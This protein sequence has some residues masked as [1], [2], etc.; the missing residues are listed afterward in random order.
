M[1]SNPDTIDIVAQDPK[2][3]K[4]LLVM[5]EDRPW[6]DRAHLHQDFH[7]KAQAYAHYVLSDQFTQ[8]HPGLKATDVIV[9]LDRAHKPGPDTLAFFQQISQGLGQY[10]IGFEYEVC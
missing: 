6:K 8:D 10:G 4:L 9:Q 5:T 3:G 1:M 2:R 7:A